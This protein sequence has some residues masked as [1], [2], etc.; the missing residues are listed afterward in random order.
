MSPEN[1]LLAGR[2]DAKSVL[3]AQIA[4]EIFARH[5]GPES[6]KSVRKFTED[7]LEQL[8][9]SSVEAAHKIVKAAYE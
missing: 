7:R 2:P 9:D 8:I 3:I 4:G 1:N 5:I 6:H